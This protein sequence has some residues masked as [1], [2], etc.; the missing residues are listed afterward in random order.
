M[1]AILEMYA[2]DHNSSYPSSL[3]ELSESEYRNQTETIMK[4]IN[5]YC[6]SS[7]FY[8]SNQGKDYTI[9]TMLSSG[10]FEIN[11]SGFVGAVANTGD[12]VSPEL[13]K[14]YGNEKPYI[15]EAEYTRIIINSPAKLLKND[16]WI[17]KGRSFEASFALWAINNPK[18]VI[19]IS[20]LLIVGIFSFI[21]GGIAGFIRFR[22]FKKYALVGLSNIFTLISLIL[23]SNYVKK[24]SKEDIEYSKLGFVTL[25]S[26][27]FTILL[28]SSPVIWSSNLDMGWLV[29]FGAIWVAVSWIILLIIK[30][31]LNKI[32]LKNG[33]IRTLLTIALFIIL[34]IAIG[35][36]IVLTLL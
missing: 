9:R 26:I 25:F 20:Y 10:L 6:Q 12:L 17:E 33:L 2:D 31:F 22:K 14:F 4:D 15:G 21:A 24:K 1:R 23:V 18:I 7:L 34:W 29:I 36:L 27:I 11:S 16:L 35:F 3:Q 30:F 5:Q 32:G 8:S 28:L 19:L 13:Q